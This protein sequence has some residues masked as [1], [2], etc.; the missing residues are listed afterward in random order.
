MGASLRRVLAL[1]RRNQ[2]DRDLHD[3]LAF[4]LEMRQE[5]LRRQSVSPDQA[6]KL[7]HEQFGSLI[8][9]RER[10]QDAWRVIWLDRLLQDVRGAL[11]M[12]RHAPGF[13]AIAVGSSALGI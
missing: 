9:A 7:A 2:L 6:R 4:H 12:I 8:L 5:E 11:R 10:T 1:F 13:S 3:E